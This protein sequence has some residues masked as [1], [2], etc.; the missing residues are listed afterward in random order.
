MPDNKYKPP[1][2]FSTSIGTACNV[3]S[4]TFQDLADKLKMDVHDLMRQYNSGGNHNKSP[5]G[6]CNL[7][8]AIILSLTRVQR[9]LRA[10]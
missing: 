3:K 4:R 10:S 8:T 2:A 9:Y 7:G 1:Y 6:A 5:W